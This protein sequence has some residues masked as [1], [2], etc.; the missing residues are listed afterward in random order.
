MRVFV[1]ST[2]RDLV[3]Y[4]ETLRLALQKSGL[5]FLGM[6][7]FGAQDAPPLQACLDELDTADVYL[8]VIGNCYGSSPPDNH[9]SYTELEYD[10]ARERD[11][12]CIILVI[13]DDATVRVGDLD[14]EAVRNQ[15]LRGFRDRLLNAHT[16]DRFAD[17]NQAAW[18]ALAA[19]RKLETRIREEALQGVLP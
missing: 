6:E 18:M 14:L 15:R 9:L 10:R 17:E 7:L 13:S 8:G 5:T 1:S 4:R 16:V 19:L 11:I 12:P 3:S 2:Y